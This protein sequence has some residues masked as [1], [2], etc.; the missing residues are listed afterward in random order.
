MADAAISDSNS[1]T[2]PDIKP[3]FTLS[4]LPKSFITPITDSTAYKA[5]FG[6]DD[7]GGALGMIAS[8]AQGGG[9][10]LPA[11]VAEFVLKAVRQ[12]SDLISKT[13]KEKINEYEFQLR[14][15]FDSLLQEA[16][17]GLEKISDKISAVA[18]VVHKA[19]EG[20]SMIVDKII[21]IRNKLDKLAEEVIGHIKAAYVK[22]NEYAQIVLGHIDGVVKL[23][24]EGKT[25]ST[26][27]EYRVGLMQGWSAVGKAQATVSVGAVPTP[28]VQ[29]KAGVG[30]WYHASRPEREGP[31]VEISMA[32]SATYKKAN[33]SLGEEEHI[34]EFDPPLDSL[35]PMMRY[36]YV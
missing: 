7:K 26:E 24:S 30:V 20:V 28:N 32:P 33:N 4:M 23:L 18:E 3:E 9:D 12:V 34:V 11:Q 22:A 1:E 27:K 10:A 6:K 25:F 21:E 29:A 31:I 35:V 8:L 5:I 13:I 17:K 16:V 2:K 19:K 14:K 15:K 36:A